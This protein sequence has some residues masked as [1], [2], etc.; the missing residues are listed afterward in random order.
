MR[1]V[2]GSCQVSAEVSVLHMAP[3]APHSVGTVMCVVSSGHRDCAEEAK[4][5][6][7]FPGGRTLSA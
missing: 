7:G 4:G 1:L 2:P 3:H 6:R 5:L